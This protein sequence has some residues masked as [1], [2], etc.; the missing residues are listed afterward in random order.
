MFLPYIISYF[1]FYLFIALDCFS[2]VPI[3]KEIIF[4]LPMPRPWCPEQTGWVPAGSTD[5]DDPAAVPWTETSPPADTEPDKK[6]TM[7]Q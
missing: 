1:Y 7:D 2:T 5:H 6:K 3:N 4:L